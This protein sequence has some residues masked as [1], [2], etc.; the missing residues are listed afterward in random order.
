MRPYVDA[1][2]LAEQLAQLRELEHFLRLALAR[3]NSPAQLAR[4]FELYRDVRDR[5]VE[6]DAR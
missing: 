1:Q 2:D 5:I 4:Y 6:F 3:E